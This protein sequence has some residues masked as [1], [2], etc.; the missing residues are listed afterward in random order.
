M[1]CPS[2]PYDVKN[3]AKSTYLD[4]SEKHSM[5]ESLEKIECRPYQWMISIQMKILH[6]HFYTRNDEDRRG[7]AIFRSIEGER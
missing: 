5:V 1:A 6:K 3:E 2:K 4:L 7:K